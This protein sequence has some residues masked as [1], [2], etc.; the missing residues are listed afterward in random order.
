MLVDWL[1][2]A[3][4]LVAIYVTLQE[5]RRNNAV[6]VSIEECVASYQ[7]SV[8]ENGGK[9]FHRFM[10]R[11][12]NK[13][14]ALYGLSAAICFRGSDYSGMHSLSMRRKTLVGDR[15]EFGKGMTAEFHLKSYEMTAADKEFLAQ[16]K[17]ARNQGATVNFY[18]Q[19]YLCRSFPVHTRASWLKERWNQFARFVN[20]RFE[21]SMG[22]GREGHAIVWTPRILPAFTVFLDGLSF[23]VS[24]IQKP[25][26]QRDR[27][28]SR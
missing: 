21:R 14:I 8:H 9:P 22:V 13:G 24:S 26:E 11:I 1:A 25:E 17:S 23:F 16:L 15:D 28:E 5:A 20:S 12:R 19:G 6:C 27:P 10:V 2:F 3:V 7:Q 4:S 18:S